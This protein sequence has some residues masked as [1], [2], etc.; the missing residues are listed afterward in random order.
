M[1]V[2]LD[3]PAELEGPLLAALW[4]R[5]VLAADADVIAACEAECSRRGGVTPT[6]LIAN[7]RR[8]LVA[9][10]KK[11]DEGVTVVGERRAGPHGYQDIVSQSQKNIKE[12]KGYAEGQATYETSTEKGKNPYRRGKGKGGGQFTSKEHSGESTPAETTDPNKPRGKPL[13]EDDPSIPK[14]SPGG[15]KIKDFRNGMMI[16]EDGTRYD[17][18]GWRNAK[19]QALD[20]NGN[21]IKKSKSDT[22]TSKTALDRAKE[23]ARD[24]RR[25]AAKEEREKESR[26]WDLKEARRKADEAA[27]EGD[28]GPLLSI[29]EREETAA[30]KARDLA[31]NPDARARL[32]QRAERL[33]RELAQTERRAEQAERREDREKG[34][35]GGSSSDEDEQA[36]L[37]K[38]VA[39][40]PKWEKELR[41]R[42]EGVGLSEAEM[43]DLIIRDRAERIRLLPR[44]YGSSGGDRPDMPARKKPPAKKPP[45]KAKGKGRDD[46]LEDMPRI[47]PDR[48]GDRHGRMETTPRVRMQEDDAPVKSP[49]GA[50]LIRFSNGV[51]KYADGSSYDGTTWKDRTGKPLRA[52]AHVSA[53]LTAAYDPALHPKGK[54][55]KWIKKFGSSTS[56]TCPASNTVNA[57]RSRSKARS[58]RSSPTRPHRATRS[59]ASR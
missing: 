21:V 39:Q 1:D 15:A 16:Y 19:G 43:K 46:N 45:A 42:Y 44:D 29:L 8:P 13:Q 38:I 25:D 54:D 58:S 24:D 40:Y 41:A 3:D 32:A 7:T 5:A 53:A 18:Q 17:A 27:G 57:A 34:S 14:R 33:G 9:A 50:K 51:A 26:E 2:L 20:D 6:R 4:T 36:R 10:S 22:S 11:K 55:G 49:G 52:R 48:P 56:S 37:R 35:S 23:K 28:Y 47:R 31:K 30:R 12:G 59:S